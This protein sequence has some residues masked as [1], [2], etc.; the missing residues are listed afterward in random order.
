VATTQ[1]KPGESFRQLR[2]HAPARA[3]EVRRHDEPTARGGFLKQSAPGRRGEAGVEAGR[4]PETP[5]RRTCSG[6]CTASPQNTARPS[7]RSMR[8]P[9]LAPGLLGQDFSRARLRLTAHRHYFSNTGRA[10]P[11]GLGCPV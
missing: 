2:A 8:G 5:G 6:L 11:V 9:H 10:G 7:G 3:A 1:E 4:G